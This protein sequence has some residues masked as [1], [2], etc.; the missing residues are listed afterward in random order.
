MST[1]KNYPYLAGMALGRLETLAYTLC[2]NQLVPFDK[3][4]ELQ[5]FL[6][7]EVARLRKAEADHSEGITEA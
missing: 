1:V 3:Y 2:S 6:D 7:A 5:A 4:K